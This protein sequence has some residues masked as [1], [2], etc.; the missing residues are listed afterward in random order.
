MYDCL[1]EGTRTF[2]LVGSYPDHV[3]LDT[4]VEES[5]QLRSQLLPGFS[6]VL[7]PLQLLERC[8]GL[9]TCR[10]ANTLIHQINTSIDLNTERLSMNKTDPNYKVYLQ[11]IF[12]A[13]STKVES[14]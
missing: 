1:P 11:A 14:I 13:T 2:G 9:N 8:V 3:H 12:R 10:Y 6:H 7:E 5:P 4:V